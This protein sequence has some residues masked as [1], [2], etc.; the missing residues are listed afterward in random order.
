MKRTITISEI[1]H[2]RLIILKYDNKFK[3]LDELISFLL[4]FFENRKTEGEENAG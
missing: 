4:D 2:K 3:N 1:T